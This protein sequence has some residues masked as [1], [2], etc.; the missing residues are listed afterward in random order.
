MNGKQDKYFN[1]EIVQ[2][3]KHTFGSVSMASAGP[4]LNASEFYFTTANSIESLNGKHTIFGQV[5]EESYDTLLK[6]NDSVVDKNGKPVQVLRIK[7]AV[8]LEDPF[9]DPDGLVVPS[10]PIVIPGVFDGLLP[11]DTT[12]DEE[13]NVRLEKLAEINA[14]SKAEVLVLLGDRPDA[15]TKP[16]DNVLFICKLN[17]ETTAEDL[18]VIFSRFGEVK[19]V[20]IIKDS[21]T[22]NSLCYGFIEFEDSDSCEEAYFKMQNVVIDN[23]RIH[24]DFSQSVAKSVN[25]SKYGGWKNY[26]IQEIGGSGKKKE[27][28]VS[29][30]HNNRGRH[31]ERGR[32][33]REYRRSRSRERD[34]RRRSRSRERDFRRNSR[35]RDRDSRRRD[36]SRSNERRQRSR[37]RERGR[38]EYRRSRSREMRYKRKERN[39]D[40]SSSRERPKDRVKS[41]DT[42]RTKRYD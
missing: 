27:N 3:F 14:R 41:S 18:G 12:I 30:R 16:P 9:P 38:K 17:P 11:E 19:N 4:H 28:G 1:D 32:G 8:V 6:I 42:K 2:E 35:S 25:F 20:D 21:K 36:R 22:G 7:K 24:V 40:R 26:F 15:D 37:S 31:N 33:Q 39:S 29:E 34:F 10:E 13:E 23:R 5:L